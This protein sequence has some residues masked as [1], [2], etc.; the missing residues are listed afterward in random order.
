MSPF[1]VFGV[2]VLCLVLC[3]TLGYK[4]AVLR[5][6]S[7]KYSAQLTE[8]KR[9]KKELEDEKEKLK[10][11]KSYVKTD[12]YVEEI[13][14]DKLGLVYPNEIIFEPKDE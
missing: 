2:V 1:T 12:D 8:L 5:A 4:T 7:A 6:Q 9:E 10:D 13:A 14:R 11:Y 3:G